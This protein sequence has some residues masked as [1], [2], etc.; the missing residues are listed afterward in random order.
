MSATG[1]RQFGRVV[2]STGTKVFSLVMA[3]RISEFTHGALSD[4]HFAHR[5]L[6]GNITIC[7]RGSGVG[8]LSRSD[9][10]E[11]AVVS[12]VTRSRS[13]G[14]SAHIQ[15]NR[16]RTVGGNA[17]LNADGVCNC[18]G[19][20]NGLVVSRA[21]TSFIERLFRVCTAKGFDVG[22][23]RGRFCRGKVQGSGNGVLSRSA[24]DGV[25][26]GPGC[27]NCCTKGGIQVASL[28]AG[29]RGFL[30]RRR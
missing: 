15:F 19:G 20:S 5:L 25:V 11:L 10:L 9:R 13:E 3:G 17:M 1:H 24:V 6:S 29:G 22:R 7:F 30:P 16:R 27:G 12:S 26:H 14:V 28:F 8:A 4:V 21:R 2:R 18:V 23:V